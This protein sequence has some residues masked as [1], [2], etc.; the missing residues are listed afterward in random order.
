M[1]TV[2][3][4]LRVVLIA[5]LALVIFGGGWF[6]GRLGIGSVVEPAS[7]TEAE[8]QFAEGMRN[9]ALVGQ[10][11]VAG[12]ES[13][14]PNPDRY[15]IASVEK[16][17]TDLWRFTAKMSCCGLSGST[18]PIT[19]PMRWVGDTPVIMMTDTSLPGV[20]TFTV[21]LLFYGD[22]YAGTWQHGAV[23]GHMSGRIEKQTSSTQ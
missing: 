11:T 13:R 2:R 14:N 16:V 3:G 19:V 6:V 12:K 5:V 20:G 1:A 17:G 22:R 4:V 15:E 7:L 18:I 8:R 9:V 23:G 21:R 10:F